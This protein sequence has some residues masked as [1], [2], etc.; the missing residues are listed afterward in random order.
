MQTTNDILTLIAHAHEESWHASIFAAVA[1]MSAN[2]AGLLLNGLLSR[3]EREPTLK[4]LLFLLAAACLDHI[5]KVAKSIEK[6]VHKQVRQVLP[7]RTMA[8]AAELARAGNLAVKPLE[9][10]LTDP[11]HSGETHSCCLRALF[12]IGGEAALQV[13]E[14]YANSFKNIRGWDTHYYPE[15]EILR[16]GDA[17]DRQQYQ[18]RV[19]VP[20]L[21]DKESLNLRGEISLEG[22]PDLP[23][24]KTLILERW[25]GKLSSLAFLA[26]SPHLRE[27]VLQHTPKKLKSLKDLP[28]LT[29]LQEVEL[30]W[31][32]NNVDIT[33]LSRLPNLQRLKLAG[34]R[35]NPEN[36]VGFQH[37][38]TT[39]ETLET[40]G[41]SLKDLDGIAHLTELRDLTLVEEYNLS[42]ARALEGLKQLEKVTLKAGSLQSNTQVL[43]HVHHLKQLTLDIGQEK[44]PDLREFPSLQHLQHLVLNSFQNTSMDLASLA[45]LTSLE[46]LVLHVSSLEGIGT[47]TALTSL[48]TVVLQIDNSKGLSALATLP[49]LRSLQL[50]YC[51]DLKHLA[52]LQGLSQL[53]TLQINNCSLLREISASALPTNL[54]T[55]QIKGCHGLTRVCDLQR[56]T[57]LETLEISGSWNLAQVEGLQGL[58]SLHTLDLHTFD[59]AQDLEVLTTLPHL[60]TV[61]VPQTCSQEVIDALVHMPGIQFVLQNNVAI[62]KQP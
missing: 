44:L 51:D 38:P 13:L 50:N 1:G 53:E 21:S 8:Q 20:L 6:Q 48:E 54:R 11:K 59:H 61:C 25:S 46:T 58:C 33:A 37:L 34:Y 62:W 3:A 24:L 14:T 41:C 43:R 60:R 2:D 35:M 55:L 30:L 56:L 19:L 31:C 40:F 4:P 45:A 49:H 5:K 32:F 7:P 23:A 18:Q 22:F 57:H 12:L 47:L 39:I 27:L 52:G 29:Q 42:D 28:A 16:A 36:L 17:F 15:Y 26:N 9:T 10:H